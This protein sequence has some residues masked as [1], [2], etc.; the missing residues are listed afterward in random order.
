MRPDYPTKL[1]N[2]NSDSY[3]CLMNALAENWRALI[4]NSRIQVSF[5]WQRSCSHSNLCYWFFII[6]T[7]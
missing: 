6:K 5:W 3:S 2:D 4:R 7:L 1:F